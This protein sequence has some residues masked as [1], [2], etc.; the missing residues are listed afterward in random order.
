MNR[1]C[2]VD[3]KPPKIVSKVQPVQ[4]AAERA[5]VVIYMIQA[6]GEISELVN[7]EQ[8]EEVP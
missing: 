7:E 6:L 2:K 1:H 4:V 5:R 3:A 8:M